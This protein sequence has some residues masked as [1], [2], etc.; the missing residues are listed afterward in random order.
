M[1]RRVGAATEKTLV[2]VLALTLGTKGKSA[3]G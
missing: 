2:P 3:L 1:F